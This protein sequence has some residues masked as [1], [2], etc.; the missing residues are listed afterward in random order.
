V[1]FENGRGFLGAEINPE[2]KKLAERRISC[3][4]PYLTL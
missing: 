2:Y 4:Q 3:S 1:A